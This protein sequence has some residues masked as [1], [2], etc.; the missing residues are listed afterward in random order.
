MKYEKNMT[1]KLGGEILRRFDKFLYLPVI[2]SIV[3]K[4]ILYFVGF[5]ANFFK[6]MK[7][8][9]KFFSGTYR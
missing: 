9:L 3:E 4:K 5:L 8:I 1:Q 6:F 7:K 2:K